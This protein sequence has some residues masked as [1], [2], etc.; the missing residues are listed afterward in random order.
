MQVYCD[1]LC[2]YCGAET[3]AAIESLRDTGM[4]PQNRV[5]CTNC[6]REYI[7]ESTIAIDVS[8]APEAG[9]ATP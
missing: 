6:N 8:K 1:T 5:T 7:V 2:P 4:V 3:W 9:K